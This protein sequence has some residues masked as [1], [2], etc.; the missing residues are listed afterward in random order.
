MLG[1]ALTVMIAPVAA[2]QEAA[3]PAKSAASTPDH[4]H[5][6]I[7]VTGRSERRIG[8]AQ[9]AS[10]GV[11]SGAEL[12]VHPLLRTSELAEAVPGMIAVQHSGGGKA[13]QYLIRGYNL[14]H[15]TD[16]SI[17]I[18]GMP[19][20]L[21]SHA[22]G[23][24]YLDLNGLIPET[25]DHIAYRK[26]PYR[27]AD[28]DFSF[29][30]A[31]SLDTL[32]RFERP[33]ASVTA[34]SYGYHR[35]AVGGSLDIGPGTLLL[36]TE[37][38]ANDG[39]WQLLERLHHV[40][41]FGKY[42]L[43]TGIGTLRASLSLYDARWRP[44]EQIP[45]RAIGNQ[46]PDRFGTLDPFLRGSTNREVFNI[47]LTGDHLTATAYA[48]HYR[49]DLLSNFTFFL[50]DPVRGD[51]LEQAE[52]R[53]TYGA[54][55]AR[56]FELADA[57]T[58]T[59]G[60]DGQTD[61]IDRLG[62]YHTQFGQRIGT[63]SLV[64]ATETSLSGYAEASWKPVERISLLAGARIDHFRF[65]TTARAGAG[66]TGAVNDTIATPKAG[67]NIQVA[68]GLAIYANY[69]QGFHSNAIRGVI[70]PGDATPA[71]A[72]ATG[73]E[74]G[75]R[76]ERGPLILA[77]DH[78]WSRAS[79]ELVYSGDDGT[80]SPTG[81]SRR[82]GYEVTAYLKPVRWL[83]IDAVYATNHA[84]FVDAPGGDRIPNALE[85]AG[86]L[87]LA[88]IFGR[89][90]AA[91]RVRYLG[92]HPLIEDNSVRSPATTVVNLRAA[93][94]FGP[95]EV[96]AEMLNIFDTARA[97]ADYY[98]ASRLP[99]EPVDGIEGIHSRTVEPRM[100]RIGATITL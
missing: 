100:L 25:V 37:V 13:A 20:N 50:N 86:E 49:F 57:L 19:Y 14:D 7:V 47:G 54:R 53:W 23:H 24:G 65:R 76:F 22:H 97:D 75:T 5:S 52:N 96:T 39:R 44:T 16:F 87:G 99:G 1:Q 10:E 73:Y 63:T 40:G 58:L 77:I 17:A 12:R 62:L 11:V 82:R 67:A 41:A 46:I 29:V 32:D 3:P 66:F 61:R 78:W 89:F 34:G 21:R 26:G 72:R 88:T 68:R 48:Q 51:E 59:I 33:F 42:T 9:S 79:S 84:R 83:A 85:G 64:D 2:S 27:A 35:L 90:N 18:D 31:A 30:A 92:P 81:P 91:V 60:A 98:Y 93:R 38:K 4:D 55:I 28:G 56:R 80:V 71:L 36:A 70:A 8:T 95:V 15:G 43:E 94:R 6:D 74:V 69:G 45:V